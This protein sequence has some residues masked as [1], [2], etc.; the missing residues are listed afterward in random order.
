[1][2]RLSYQEGLLDVIDVVACVDMLLAD[3]KPLENIDLVA[4]PD[5]NFLVIMKDEKIY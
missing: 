2:L 4:D 3:G 1:V 5:N